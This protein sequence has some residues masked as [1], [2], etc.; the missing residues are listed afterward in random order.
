MTVWLF[1][2]F[3]VIA[4]GEELSP[5]SSCNTMLFIT[6]FGPLKTTITTVL[7]MLFALTFFSTKTLISFKDRI[8]KKIFQ[9]LN[10]KLYKMQKTHCKYKKRTAAPL[11]IKMGNNV[12]F[13]QVSKYD[14]WSPTK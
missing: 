14:K 10:N 2:L 11:H 1:V 8:S 5:K 6:M 4:M 7:K 12:D 3:I 9:K 13:F